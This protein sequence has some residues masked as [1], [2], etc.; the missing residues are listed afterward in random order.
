M[1]Y[2]NFK[3]AI[4]TFSVLAL[5]CISQSCKDVLDETVVSGIGNDY[6][7]TA[8]GFQDASNAAYSALRAYYA[9]QPGLTFSEYGTD[10]YATG[11]DGSYKGFHFYDAQ[12]NPNIDYLAGIWD[13]I[14]HHKSEI[15]CK[16]R[17]RLWH[18]DRYHILKK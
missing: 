5:L 14:G 13:L 7:N 10:L 8:K 2:I 9:T 4:T 3:K 6:I 12:L 15:P 17:L 16:N 11:A 1:K 18:K